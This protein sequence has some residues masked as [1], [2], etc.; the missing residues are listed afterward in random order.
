MVLQISGSRAVWGIVGPTRC[1]RRLEFLLDRRGFE[2]S[3]P[4]WFLASVILIRSL[5][6]AGAVIE[7]GCNEPPFGIL[8]CHNIAK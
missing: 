7:E 1:T 3:H 4:T 6:F 5:P 8:V 2:R